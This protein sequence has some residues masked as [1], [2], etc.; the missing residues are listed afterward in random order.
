MSKYSH[1][2]N[3]VKQVL[4]YD[5]ETNEPIAVKL[6]VR[7]KFQTRKKESTVCDVPIEDWDFKTMNIVKEKA[8]LYEDLIR[9]INE[10]KAR[11]PH[12]EIQLNKGEINNIEALRKAKGEKELIKG[13]VLDFVFSLKPYNRVNDKLTPQTLK[14]LKSRSRSFVK[15]M[16]DKFLPL[17]F[18]KLQLRSSLEDMVDILYDS[19]IKVQTIEKYLSALD[20]ACKERT[21]TD[22]SPFKEANLIRYKKSQSR[23][24]VVP[25]QNLEQGISRIETLQDLEAYLVWLLSFTLLGI[26]YTDIFNI[27]ESKIAEPKY[28][29]KPYHPN[30][31]E[32]NTP[33]HIK[34]IRGKVEDRKGETKVVYIQRMINLYPTYVIM[35]MLK[36]IIKKTRPQYA[37]KGSDRLRIFNFKT[38]NDK[39]ETTTEGDR[40]KDL[41]HSTY[42]KKWKKT[43]GNGISDTRATSMRAGKN[44]GVNFDELEAQL[45]HVARSGN[46]SGVFDTYFSPEQKRIDTNHIFSLMDY[47]VMKL[48]GYIIKRVKITGKPDWLPKHIVDTYDEFT[49]TPFDF[50]LSLMSAEEFNEMQNLMSRHGMESYMD[51][52][53]IVQYRKVPKNRYPERLKELTDKLHKLQYEHLVG[54]EE[55]E[56]NRNYVGVDI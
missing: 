5:K 37:Y 25:F 17:T 33:L 38:R 45:G 9:D 34:F 2:L 4:I 51:E 41:L 53:G 32:Y 43:I 30:V 35:D 14:N 28:D 13:D 31:P 39:G 15:K 1:T 6:G 50:P 36:H 23:Q 12:L 52:L 19:G 24:E 47:D 29:L 49:A 44:V 54:P 22:W 27:D 8:E 42:L 46:V 56:S 16:P 18:D 55:D 21:K 40:L 26:N 20:R 48:I 3:F 7:H 11:L 10:I